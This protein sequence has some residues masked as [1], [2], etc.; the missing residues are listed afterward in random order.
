MIIQGDPSLMLI[1]VRS[2]D[3]FGKFSLPHSLNIPL[4]N[5]L[6]EGN[7]GYFG[8]P[9]TKVVFI[10]D[11]GIKADQMWVLTK[12]LGFNSTYVMKG[13]INRWMETI[14][15]PQEPAEEEPYT[16]FETYSFRKGAQMY[17]TGGA[18]DEVETSKV[19]IQ[20]NRREK[21]SAASGGC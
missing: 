15:D 7:L 17:F 13:G 19:E 11:D 3:E 2:E 18:T 5:L 20:V 1:D 6:N 16:A 4:T 8:V 9:G 21:T 12:R 14:I 10:S